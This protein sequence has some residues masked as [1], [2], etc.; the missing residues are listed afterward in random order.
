MFSLIFLGRLI[1]SIISFFFF[2]TTFYFYTILLY[3]IIINIIIGD[4]ILIKEYRYEDTEGIL[5]IDENITTDIFLSLEEV[6]KIVQFYLNMKTKE[7]NNK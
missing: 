2:Y 3:T 7:S 4:I 1:I 5:L 6:D